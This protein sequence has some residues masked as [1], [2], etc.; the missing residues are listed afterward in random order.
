MTVIPGAPVLHGPPGIIETIPGRYRTLSY[1]IDTVHMHS[2]PLSDSMPMNT[3]A[4]A[5]KMVVDYYCNILL[6]L[7]V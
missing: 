1:A 4:I 5:L 7:S 2:Q 6:I 3:G